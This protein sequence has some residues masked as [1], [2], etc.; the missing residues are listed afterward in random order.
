MIVYQP[1]NV[2]PPTVSKHGSTFN[3]AEE[4]Q[5]KYPFQL[6]PE[7]MSEH[8]E[9]VTQLKS[10]CDRFTTGFHKQFRKGVF[11]YKCQRVNYICKTC[12]C[13]FYQWYRTGEKQS[14]NVDDD[15]ADAIIGSIVTALSLFTL[16]T[17]LSI[18]D[19]PL[20]VAFVIL[21]SEITLAIFAAVVIITIGQI[22]D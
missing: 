22:F 4:R 11:E 3:E 14:I 13:E 10:D 5:Q 12:G 8:T 18:D 19:P 20:W 1:M 15:I 21:L 17:S 9:V 7:C 6:C 16:V 2:D